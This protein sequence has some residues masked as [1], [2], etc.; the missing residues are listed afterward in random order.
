MSEGPQSIKS[1]ILDHVID[2]GIPS[3]C[4]TIPLLAWIDSVASVLRSF[5][6]RFV[7][8]SVSILFFAVARLIILLL[9]EK[10]NVRTLNEKLSRDFRIYLD[11]VKGK[12]VYR[13]KRNGEIICP[14]CV[15]ERNTPSPMAIES[16]YYVCGACD[17]MVSR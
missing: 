9:R 16:E 6:W 15:A 17:N 2:W 8:V 1:R 14:R 4:S 5:G 11:P 7:T 13:D 3:L 10:S 12:G